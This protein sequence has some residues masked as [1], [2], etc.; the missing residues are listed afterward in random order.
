MLLLSAVASVAAV[1]VAGCAGFWSPLTSTTSAGCTTSCTTATGGDFYILNAA[2]GS[3]Q[4][5]GEQIISGKL[6][7]ISGS[8]WSVPAAPY[9][10]AIAPSGNFLY[11]STAAGVYVYAISGGALGTSTQL[12]TDAS[13][14][15]IAVDPSGNWLIEA[16][17]A[18]TNG[19][20]TLAA[21]P[22]NS[23]TGKNNGT[24][25]T[26]TATIAN[27]AVQEGKIA[28][29]P[30]DKYIFVAL[31]TGGTII[32]PFAS[33]TAA[34]SNPFSTTAYTVPV[35]NAGGSALSVAVDPSTTP[36]LFYIG[37]SLGNSAAT[38]GG[39]RAIQ[40]SS[41]GSTLLNAT[42][43]PL[44]SGG[45]APNAILPVGT[46]YVYV[47]NGAGTTTAG[48]INTFSIVTSNSTYTIT[49]GASVASGIQPFSLAEDGTGT[50]VLAA[51]SLGTPYFSSYTF[52][53]TTAG[54]LDEQI[55]TSTGSSP[56]AIVALP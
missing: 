14:L 28:I 13:A 7:A 43:S 45:L 29:S 53:G 24:E 5:A 55:F 23:T 15:A 42:G 10:M 41:I 19:G 26:T 36:R 9:S 16:E 2:S 33:T 38:S 46:S 47:G 3:P 56:I 30:D 32:A 50:F 22:I 52:D 39:L 31:G 12:T 4:I 1:A 49:S 48:T 40:Y 11:V 44:A 27:A 34:G 18:T 37:E 8:P 51:N 54:Q 6:T 25:A 21:V 17:Q 35:L 20:I